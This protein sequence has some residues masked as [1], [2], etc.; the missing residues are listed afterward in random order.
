MLFRQIFQYQRCSHFTTPETC[1][2]V[3]MMMM[4]IIIIHAYTH[5]YLGRVLRGLDFLGSCSFNKIR[6]YSGSL[7]LRK[8]IHI[9][10]SIVF[11][12]LLTSNLILEKKRIYLN[13][14]P[15]F[16]SGREMFIFLGFSWSLENL[17]P[18]LLKKTIILEE[19]ERW[20][21][22]DQKSCWM[23]GCASYSHK[24]VKQAKDKF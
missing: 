10:E 18:F 15:S 13:L 24:K 11:L 7:V 23:F 8:E 2:V 3:R 12:L 21:H 5:H 22:N 17:M 19:D 14:F 1:V 16:F 9:W 20:F 6:Y 4:I